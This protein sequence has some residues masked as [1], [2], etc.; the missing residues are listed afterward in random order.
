M[1][2]EMS[3]ELLIWSEKNKVPNQKNNQIMAIFKWFQREWVLI[4]NEWNYKKYKSI[5]LQNL[6]NFYGIKNEFN[7]F[8]T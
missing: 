2:I 1:I 6:I 3:I 5:N 8:T 7:I 4:I